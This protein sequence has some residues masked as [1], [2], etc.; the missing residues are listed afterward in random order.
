VTV[1]VITMNRESDFPY[2]VTQFVDIADD[3]A[4]PFFCAFCAFLRLFLLTSGPE[5][6]GSATRTVPF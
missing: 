5:C 3:C 4:S 6:N 2:K 1:F